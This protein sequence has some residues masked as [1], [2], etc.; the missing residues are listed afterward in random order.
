MSVTT[1]GWT[2]EGRESGGVHSSRS[3]DLGAQVSAGVVREAA[4][5]RRRRPALWAGGV[6]LV[7]VG[8][9]GTA[10]LVGGAGNRV[11]VL[12]VARDVPVGQTIAAGDLTVARVA[13]DPALQPVRASERGRVVGRVAAVE[14]RPGSLLTA[15][16]LTDTAVPGPGEQVVGV[17]A[18]PGQLPA[19]GL[20]PGDRILLVPVP[21]DAAGAGGVSGAADGA[22][23]PVGESLP[24]RVMQVC[25]ADANGRS[26]VD[27]L[28]SREVGPR[29][30]ALA[31]T[32]RVALVL[33]SASGR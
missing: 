32:G 3:G 29:V 30:A 11:E 23:V 24:A 9:L 10:G 17:A 14:L 25:A 20:R 15:G 12:A 19:R 5:P 6:A 33:V 31:S 22:A 16:E 8:A 4:V 18:S 26:T 27:V 13:A 2:A 1:S 21:G 28:V 7:A